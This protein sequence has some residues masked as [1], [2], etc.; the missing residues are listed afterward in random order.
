M[1][2]VRIAKAKDK[3]RFMIFGKSALVTAMP[4][5]IGFS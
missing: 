4:F 2:A 3:K 1:T 5:V